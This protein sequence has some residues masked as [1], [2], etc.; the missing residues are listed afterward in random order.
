[1]RPHNIRVPSEVIPL[2]LKG[3]VIAKF[4]GDLA[5]HPLFQLQ[6]RGLAVFGSVENDAGVLDFLKIG[7]T[8]HRS[9]SSIKPS[10]ISLHRLR[11]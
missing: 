8:F 9:S 11:Y 4:R 5:L 2:R 6:R 1:M 10:T 3:E 7:S